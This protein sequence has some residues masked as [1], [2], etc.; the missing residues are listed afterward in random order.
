[1]NKAV[2][3]AF[4]VAERLASRGKTH[5]ML[6]VLEELFD[7]NSN[8]TDLANRIGNQLLGIGHLSKATEYFK[9]ALNLDPANIIA[10][11]GLAQVAHDA[12]RHDE[13]RQ[14]Y[15]ALLKQY[16]DNPVIRRNAL[17]SAEYD[18][19]LSDEE[20]FK[21]ALAWGTWIQG[22]TPTRNTTSHHI[23]TNRPLNIGYVSADLCQH[24]VGLLAKDIITNHNPSRVKAFVYNATAKRDWVTQ[25][26]HT[27]T[28][29][30]DIHHL[31]D[32]A[33]ETLIRADHIDVLVDLSGH[34]A[35]SRLSVF[36]RKPAP[37]QI[38]WL[39][40]FATTG[41]QTMDAVL[42]DEGH[43][44]SETQKNFCEKI[45]KLPSR[46]YF[47]PLDF[48]PDVS[49]PPCI[50]NGYITFGCFNNTAKINTE[51]IK[52]WSAILKQVPDSRL[53]LKWRTFIDP[54]FRE[55]TLSQ[56]AQ[57]SI[58][59]HRIELRGASFHKELLK[60]YADIDIALDPFPFTG[61]MSSL[62][63]LWMGVPIIT[64]NGSRVV[65]WQT[66]AILKNIGASDQA[67]ESKTDYVNKGIRLA[68][69]RDKLLYWRNSS[70]TQIKQ[71]NVMNLELQ[72]KALEQ[73]FYDL[74]A[75][76]FYKDKLIY[77]P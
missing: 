42:L 11:T 26:I 36:A 14:S 30:R 47:A 23:N 40:Y 50:K 18:P 48:Y 24:T 21:K 63:A 53:V 28:Q 60:Q 41:L 75:E 70:R 57:S 67:C 71:S 35:G 61:G 52:L 22:Q 44:T 69:E 1:V 38:S 62:E 54:V 34:T 55:W 9:R 72:V 39:G 8:N 27:K 33:L 68:R 46:F 3:S 64:L 6:Y 73:C 45:V 5:E 58:E 37:V 51:V 59:P 2:N 25:D 43:T 10:H 32:N 20:R 29:F 7:A 56:F 65:N 17:L 66:A 16:P 12:G 31:D 76:S 49:P 19:S 4:A 74:F 15:E 13:A 77:H